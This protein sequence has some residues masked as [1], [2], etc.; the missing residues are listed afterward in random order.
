MQGRWSDR[1]LPAGPKLFHER[2]RTLPFYCSEIL[3]G[4][5]LSRLSQPNR[6]T[7]LHSDHTSKRPDQAGSNVSA[8]LVGGCNRRKVLRD[9]Y[10]PAESSRRET[11]L[12][13]CRLSGVLKGK[14][15]R[16]EGASPIHP[17]LPPSS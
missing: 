4:L 5:L 14:R 3:P 8:A 15:P 12:S 9:E 1:V 10:A 16:R 7:R 17:T 11:R 13:E 2:A 6:P